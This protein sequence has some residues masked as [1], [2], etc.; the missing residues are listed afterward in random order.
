MTRKYSRGQIYRRKKMLDKMV[1]VPEPNYSPNLPVSDLWNNIATPYTGG[2]S[3]V[4][5]YTITYPSTS[6]IYNGNGYI[7]TGNTSGTIL[8]K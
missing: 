2:T 5:P 1:E 4:V 6:Y 7:D 8:I 3:V